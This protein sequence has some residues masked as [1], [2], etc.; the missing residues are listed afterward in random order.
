M[1]QSYNIGVLGPNSCSPEEAL[2]GMQTGRLIAE[3]GA[4]LICGG[5]GGMMEAA[6]K[7]AKEAGGITVG[8]LP[9]DNSADANA[10]IDVALPTGMGAFRNMM[11][12]RSCSAVIAIHGAY[13]TLSEIAFAL[14]IGVPV[15]GLYTWSLMKN[16]KIDTGIIHAKT[17]EEAVSKALENTCRSQV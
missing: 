11:L 7:G 12:V 3:A 13:G 6:A 8:I 9:T 17:P 5:M 16:G 15:I 14:R 1:Q 2:L 4:T 10:F